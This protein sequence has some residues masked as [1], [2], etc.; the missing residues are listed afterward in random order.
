MSQEAG[1]DLIRSPEDLRGDF[2][3]L[4]ASDLQALVGLGHRVFRWP[5]LDW[6]P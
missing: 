3:P 1:R 5:G 2:N 4:P 6:N